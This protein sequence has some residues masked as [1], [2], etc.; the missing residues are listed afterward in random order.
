MTTTVKSKSP[1]GTSWSCEL[2]SHSEFLAWGEQA[3]DQAVFRR[4]MQQEL[5]GALGREAKGTYLGYCTVCRQHSHFTYDWSFSNGR[6]INWREHLVCK[7]CGLNNRLRLMWTEVFSAPQRCAAD[8][9]LTEHLTPLASKLKREC[10]K[11]VTSEFLGADVPRGKVNKQ[12]IRNEDITC[13][14][15]ADSSFDLVLSFD[16]LEHVPEYRRALLEVYRVLRRDGLLV[17]SVPFAL[18]SQSNIV[19]ARVLRSGQVEHLLPPEFHGDPV[20]PEKGVLCF[21]HFGWELL[22][23]IRSFG[24]RDVWLTLHW[25]SDHAHIGNEQI[26]LWARK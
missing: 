24:F 3:R 12:G 13:L 19:R 17:L 20:D 4:Q 22:D 23:D 6:E 2:R 7:T 15:F 10:R 1:P 5:E 16:V 21:Y 11:L 8:I 14:T 25:S 9:Y 18:I 26:L